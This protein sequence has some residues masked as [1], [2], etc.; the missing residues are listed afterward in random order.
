MYAPRFRIGQRLAGHHVADHV[1]GGQQQRGAVGHLQRHRLREPAQTHLALGN[2]RPRP[3]PV[4]AAVEADPIGLNHHPQLAGGVPPTPATPPA[5]PPSPHEHHH[6]R[7]EATRLHAPSTS[8]QT[9]QS[10]RYRRPTPTP[11]AAAP[12]HPGWAARPTSPH[13]PAA[14]PDPR[15]D[16]R[17]DRGAGRGA[18]GVA[19]RVAHSHPRP[20]RRR[21][22]ARATDPAPDDRIRLPAPPCGRGRWRCCR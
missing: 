2:P 21:R 12:P 6:R 13:R 14:P 7:T 3:L 10:T 15:A 4:Q 5:T 1:P 8:R 19:R 9:P 20:A 11:A 17:A 16:P 18:G 22:A